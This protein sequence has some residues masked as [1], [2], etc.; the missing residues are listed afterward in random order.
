M[1]KNNIENLKQTDLYSLL[2]FVLYKM[3][4]NAQY[5]SLSQL[6]YVL[7][8]ENLL[9]FCEFFGGQTIKVPTTQELETLI[10]GLLLYQYV[11]IDHIEYSEA[12]KLIGI[13]ST[14]SR[15]LKTAYT[16]ICKTMQEYSFVPQEGV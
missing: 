7:D 14:E 5:S 11:K 6:A 15:Q 3:T 8:K 2:L 16:N 10:S 4:N 9:N 12:L 1:I 13:S